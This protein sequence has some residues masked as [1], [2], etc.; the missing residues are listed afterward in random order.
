MFN[1]PPYPH[2]YSHSQVSVNKLRYVTLKNLV[3]VF[4]HIRITYTPTVAH[5]RTL[6][7]FAICLIYIAF[8]DWFFSLKYFICNYGN[9][10]LLKLLLLLHFT[11]DIASLVMV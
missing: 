11:T 2:S 4:V 7:C 9:D 8:S 3:C 6:Y 5:A 1:I 10:L